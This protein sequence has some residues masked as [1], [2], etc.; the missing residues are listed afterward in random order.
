M[1]TGKYWLITDF[2]AEIN[3]DISV[4]DPDTADSFWKS[5]DI[6]WSRGQLEK[7]PDTERLHWQFVVCFNRKGRLSK[8][9][10]VLG[11][12]AHAELTRSDAAHGYVWKDETSVGRRWEWGNLP[13]R[14]NNATDWQTV[15]DSA[16][17]GKITDIAPQIRV[18]HYNSL[19]KIAMDNMK[20]VGIEK[21]VK[22]LWGPT[23]VGKSRLAWDEA[24]LDAY[25]KTPT[26][27]FWDGYQGQEHVVID[28]FFGQI[29]ISHMLRW[30]DRYPVNIETKGS[31][32]V[33]KA[34]KIWITSNLH[35]EEWYRLAP[36]S[37]VQA[38][39]RRL[40][41]IHME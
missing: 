24:G 19:R 11:R 33:L 32:T 7:C 36:E 27:K 28:E 35:P 30:L 29:E 10:T 22:V 18:C 12:E 14:R 17:D 37:Q 39:L 40:N 8:V 41:V 34:K 23:G 13:I 1:S 2:N 3:Y 6:C 38:L 31:G 26:T 16:V 20:P 5:K 9:K 25:P 21:E 15:W 4:D